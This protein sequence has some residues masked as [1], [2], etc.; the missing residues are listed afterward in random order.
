MEHVLR[1]QGREI[2]FGAITEILLYRD[3]G[4]RLVGPLPADVQNYTAYAAAQSTAAPSP[5]A[6]AALLRF[7]ATPASKAL[8]VAAGIE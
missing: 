1:G 2:G 5:E 6:A 3:K 4:L 8:F 7:L